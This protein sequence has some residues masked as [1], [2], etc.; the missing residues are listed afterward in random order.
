VSQV[1]IT[2]RTA[3]FRAHHTKTPIGDGAD[4]LWCDRF[5]KTRPTCAGIELGAGI[6]QIVAAAHALKDPLAMLVEQSAAEC[7]LSALSSRDF[8]LLLGQQFAPRL[9]TLTNFIFRYIAIMLH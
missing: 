5:Q 1:R 9:I 6:K 7:R 4:I 2:Q 8:I 3:N